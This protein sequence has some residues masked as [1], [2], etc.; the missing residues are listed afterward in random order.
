MAGDATW[1][2]W[3]DGQYPGDADAEL[4]AKCKLPG[5]FPPWTAVGGSLRG[6]PSGSDTLSQLIGTVVGKSTSTQPQA[7]AV[8]GWPTYL[9]LAGVAVAAY[10]LLK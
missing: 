5:T 4:N 8:S 3:C 1:N 10:V 9:A 6:L 7:S 2:A